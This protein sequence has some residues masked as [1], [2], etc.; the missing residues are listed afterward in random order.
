MPADKSENIPI[1]NG[2]IDSQRKVK[3]AVGSGFLSGAIEAGDGQPHT[4]KGNGETIMAGLNCGSPCT[5]AWEILRDYGSYALRCGDDAAKL[6]MRTLGR[7]GIVSGESGAAG[8]GAF[9]ELIK[10]PAQ[11]AKLGIGPDSGILFFSTE[12]NTDPE[13]YEEIMAG[14]DCVEA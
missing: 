6:G 8:V 2:F 14:A 4:A 9:L 5:V 7:Y 10:D 1:Q 13:S 12:G 3:G 11:K